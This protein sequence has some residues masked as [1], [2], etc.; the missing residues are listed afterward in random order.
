MEMKSKLSDLNFQRCLE[1]SNVV[2][3]METALFMIVS[4]SPSP[5]AIGSANFRP[6]S[7]KKWTL[8]LA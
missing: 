6:R 7:P 3:A 2:C 5:L 1:R 4:S 8:L